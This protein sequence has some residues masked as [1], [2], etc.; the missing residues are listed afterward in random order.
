MSIAHPFP[1]E[2]DTRCPNP[3]LNR[4]AVVEWLSGRIDPWRHIVSKADLDKF[5]TK[6]RERHAVLTERLGEIEEDLTELG[7]DDSAEMAIE[8]E[9]DEVLEG[10]GLAALKERQQIDLALERIR[11][12]TYGKCLACGQDIPV[13]RLEA[14]SHAATCVKCASS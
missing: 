2:Q 1:K 12:G 3:D 11:T 6:L 10:V 7:D 13:Q 5:A 14:V 8:A 4:S 9:G